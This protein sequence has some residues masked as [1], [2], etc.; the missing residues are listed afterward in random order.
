LIDNLYEISL[1]L[2]EIHMIC[3]MNYY[4]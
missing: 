4:M 2:K 1:D 3:D